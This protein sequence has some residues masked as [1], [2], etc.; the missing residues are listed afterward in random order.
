M[1][2]LTTTQAAKIL[3]VNDSRVR[4]LILSGRLPAQKLGRDWIIKEK[5]LKEAEDF[6]GTFYTL[7]DNNILPKNFA[8][9]IAPVVGVRNRI[10]HGYESL[11][12]SLFMSNL[13]KN[14]SDFE[15]YIE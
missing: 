4:Q 15:K 2:I 7:A 1:K 11:E 8:L 14:Y 13:R 6:Q 9:K 3:K 5:D 10:V 12:K